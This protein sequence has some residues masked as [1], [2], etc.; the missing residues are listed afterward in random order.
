MDKLNKSMRF[1]ELI[2]V[3]L[4]FIGPAAP[5]GLFGVLYATSDGAIA[6]VYLV[7]T[8][9]MAFTA[10][11]YARMSSEL[12]NAGAVYAY[13]S[14]G[15]N[16][17]AG[18]LVGWL[19]LLDYMFIPAVAYLFCGISINAIFP[20]VPVWSC[21]II[22]VFITIVLNLIGIKKSA[23]ITF[24]VLIAEM[25]VLSLVLLFTSIALWQT[26][27]PL[28][29]LTPFIGG[30]HF[31]WAALFKA[32]SIAVLSYLGFDAIATFAEEN[33]GK[34]SLVGKATV[35]CL[36]IVGVLFILQ[37]YLAALIS[38]Y[39]AENLQHHTELQGKAYYLIINEQVAQ[40]LGITL[41]LMKSIGAAFAAMVGQAAS[42]RLLFSMARDKRLPAILTKVGKQSG[43][44]TYALL[45][46]GLFNMLLAVIAAMQANG[47]K[48]LVS[49]V[50]IGALCTFI[51]LHLSVIG[52]FYIKKQQRGIVSLFANVIIP[53]IGIILLL[54]V[55]FTIQFSAKIIGV[56]WLAIGV[57]ILLLTDNKAELKWLEKEQH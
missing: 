45:F 55:L 33:K 50:D 52:Y 37:T 13:C 49:F 54:P 57:L 48:H 51:M 41:A 42:A 5:V 24:T 4:L 1:R 12:P 21:T 32:V 18:F 47:L 25:L 27:H 36:I 3:G 53:S 38:S 34:T 6:L 39:S 19:L 23:K 15:I 17:S 11:S 26:T 20:N 46:A 35:I 56:C 30:I 28:D 31:S 44:P 22:A 2:I 10:Y 7:A 9:V 43:V 8:I 29:W 14:A 40:W 16:P